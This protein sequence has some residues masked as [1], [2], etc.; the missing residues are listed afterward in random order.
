MGLE[1]DDLK[2]PFQPNTFCDFMIINYVNIVSY[3]Q[4]LWFP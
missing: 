4:I 3:K 1:L 2:E